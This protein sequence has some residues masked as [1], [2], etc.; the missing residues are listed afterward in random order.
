MMIETGTQRIKI[1]SKRLPSGNCQVKFYVNTD[2]GRSYY[3]YMLVASGKKVSD[4][5][6]LLHT[7][8]QKIDTP[9]AY[10]HGHLFDLGRKQEFEPGF[11][12][13]RQ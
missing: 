2:N 1:F 12:L 4:V 11:I 13:Y 9:D 7:K 5:I 3:G 8:M 10:Y 6:T